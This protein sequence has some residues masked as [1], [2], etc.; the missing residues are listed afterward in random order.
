MARTEESRHALG[1]LLDPRGDSLN[2]QRQSAFG[3]GAH[4]QST[5]RLTP[6][7]SIAGS[8]GDEVVP[9]PARRQA[10]GDGDEMRRG[11]KGGLSVSGPLPAVTAVLRLTYASSTESSYGVFRYA[12][13]VAVRMSVA[14]MAWKIGEGSTI[15]M[16]PPTA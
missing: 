10:V 5:T 15:C 9:L 16:R 11:S 12:G 8:Q 1:P 6:A 4:S 3:C 7:L 13:S 2:R 14:G